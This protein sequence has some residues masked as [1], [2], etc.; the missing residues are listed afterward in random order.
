MALEPKSLPMRY[1][2]VEAKNDA[3]RD[4]IDQKCKRLCIGL[5]GNDPYPINRD[6]GLNTM[7]IGEYF[8]T[9]EEH[10]AAEL[11]CSIYNA[12]VDALI[13]QHGI[14]NWAD[15]HRRTSDRERMLNLIIGHL[16]PRSELASVIDVRRHR[17]Y[18]L[19]NWTWKEAIAFADLP[20]HGLSFM[21]GDVSPRCGRIDMFDSTIRHTNLIA[22]EQFRR[23][24]FPQLPWDAL[25][26]KLNTS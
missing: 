26:A 2:P 8:P 5:V 14:P 21:V 7:A 23:R 19:V 6:C 22:S 18:E 11:Y 12:T 1:D 9:R 15:V 20:E 16:H 3:Q 10:I 24:H 25:T 17:V 4:W 13:A